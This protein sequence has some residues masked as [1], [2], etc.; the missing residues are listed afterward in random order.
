MRSRTGKA[1]AGDVSDSDV[2]AK[3]NTDRPFLSLD[4]KLIQLVP[5][6]GDITRASAERIDL[7]N[8]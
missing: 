8:I 5:K 7:I 4:E 1:I 6:V 2:V 3:H